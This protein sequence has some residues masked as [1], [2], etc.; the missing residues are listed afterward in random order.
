MFK[1]CRIVKFCMWYIF[2]SVFPVFLPFIVNKDVFDVFILIVSP[3]LGLE[4]LRN[5]ENC[6]KICHV[7]VNRLKKCIAVGMSR[8]GK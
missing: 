6:D 7:Y 3:D 4:H 5:V 1:L 8:D 2:F